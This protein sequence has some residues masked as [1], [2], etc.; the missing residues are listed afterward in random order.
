MNDFTTN[1]FVAFGFGDEKG[2]RVEFLTEFKE[3]S[4]IVFAYA[5]ILLAL[6][7]VWMPVAVN[8]REI[9]RTFRST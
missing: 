4:P 1:G 8:H 7:E 6:N 3:F 5:T 9:N 2:G